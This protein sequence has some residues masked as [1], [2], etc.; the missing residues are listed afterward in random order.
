METIYRGRIF[1]VCR[2]ATFDVVRHPGAAAI[3]PVMDD[4]RVVLVRQHRHAVD[5]TL[6]EIPA[7]TLEQGEEPLECAKRELVE[8]TGYE[9]SRYEH[10]CTIL[11]VPGYSDERIHLFLAVDLCLKEQNLDPDEIIDVVLVPMDEA[12]RMIMDGSIED[13]KT[14]VGLFMVNK[15]RALQ[16]K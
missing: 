11:P 8:E 14:I 16:V 3:V 7:G 15:R 2:T 4:D 10:L 5:K 13:A 9:A 12:I 6:W 1:S